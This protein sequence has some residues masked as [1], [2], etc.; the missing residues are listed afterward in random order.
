VLDLAWLDQTGI[1]PLVV[2][3]IALL[4]K[5]VATGF[6]EC[7]HFDSFYGPPLSIVAEIDALGLHEALVTEIVQIVLQ[8]PRLAIVDRLVQVLDP[9]HPEPSH[10]REQFLFFRT[11]L[12]TDDLMRHTARAACVLG[13][14][15]PGTWLSWNSARSGATFPEGAWMMGLAIAGALPQG[16]Q[17]S[18]NR[19]LRRN[20]RNLPAIRG[21]MIV[22]RDLASARNVLGNVNSHSPS[23]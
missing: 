20:R 16:V 1:D 14:Y 10:F 17:P 12:K 4:D 7:D 11:Q 21:R 22:R 13:V 2:G 19:R 15:G 18:L 6:R 23:L 3:Q 5:Q 8:L 9:D